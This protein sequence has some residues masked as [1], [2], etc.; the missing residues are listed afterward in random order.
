MKQFDIIALGELNVDLI[1]NQIEGEPEIGKEKFAKQM[2][3]TLGSS[4]AIFAA[5]AAALGAKVAFCGMIG[6]DSF[7]DLVETSLQKKGVDT[8]FLIRQD[9]YATGATICMSYDEDRAN[10]T[11]QGAMDYMGL[12]DINPEVFK[13]AKHIHISSIYMQSGVKRDLKQILELCQQN[14]VTTSLDSQW[15]P[16]EKWDLDWKA[17]LPMV[18]VFMPNETELKFLTR[19]ATLEEAIETIRPY[20]N[21]AVI[22]CG[23]KGSILMRKGMPDRRQDALLNKNV[24]DCI[25]AGDSF[26]SGFI[27]RLAAGDPLDVCQQYGNMTGAVNTT[28]AGGTTAFT[29]REDVERIGRERFGWSR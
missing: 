14:G 27:T 5:N 24:V 1:L 4:T 25:G 21:A 23:S 11:Y 17:I 9:K 13:T 6:N 16:V 18:T 12:A 28:A 2:T 8:R 7:G 20:T 22:K 26:N 3:L 10:L 19:C 15:D 29:C